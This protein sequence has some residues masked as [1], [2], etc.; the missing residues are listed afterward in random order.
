M[1]ERKKEEKKMKNRKERNKRERESSNERNG[2]STR[3][4]ERERKNDS[5]YFF[6]LV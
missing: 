2:I 5:F 6:R 3:T 1:S 4:E